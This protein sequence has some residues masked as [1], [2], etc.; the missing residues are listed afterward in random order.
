[1]K[2]DLIIGIILAIV[3]ILAI[4]FLEP[5][6]EDARCNEDYCNLKYRLGSIKGYNIK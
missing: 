2:E 6:V 5:H 4:A 3:T 1:M